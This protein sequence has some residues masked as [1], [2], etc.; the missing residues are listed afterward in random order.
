M[1]ITL[2]QAQE[3]GFPKVLLNAF[4]NLMKNIDSETENN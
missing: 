2:Y 4:D 3:N 1:K